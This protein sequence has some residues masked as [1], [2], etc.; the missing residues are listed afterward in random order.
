MVFGGL[1]FFPCECAAMDAFLGTDAA[2]ESA[3][4]VEPGES[5]GFRN[6]D[7]SAGPHDIRFADTRCGRHGGQSTKYTW[8]LGCE[9]GRVARRTMVDEQHSQSTGYGPLHH[10]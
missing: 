1:S 7:D 6:G 2:A 8:R 9:A 10:R 4:G 3:N 5:R